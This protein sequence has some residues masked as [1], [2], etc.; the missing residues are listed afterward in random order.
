MGLHVY[1]FCAKEFFG[2]VNRQLLGNVHVFAAAVIAFAGVA[3]G[4]FVG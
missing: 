1:I 3:F 2:A 4:V